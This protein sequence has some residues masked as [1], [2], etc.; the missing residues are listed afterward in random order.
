MDEKMNILINKKN[1]QYLPY[2]NNKQKG[3]ICL[4]IAFKS[5]IYKMSNF[6]PSNLIKI[7]FKYNFNKDISNFPNKITHLNL[8]CCFEQKLRKIPL[9]TKE[10]AVIN[11]VVSKIKRNKI[12]F[13]IINDC[14][15]VHYYN[16]RCKTCGC[17]D[18]W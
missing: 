2:I 18:Y 16:N 9:R 13:V 12:K 14:Y 6:L 1:K 3:L 17:C 8:S 15:K 11:K 5:Y 10:I 7:M 4:H